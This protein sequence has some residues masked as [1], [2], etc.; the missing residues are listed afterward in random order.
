MIF[1]CKIEVFDKWCGGA[2]Y[3]ADIFSVRNKT[4]KAKG[5]VAWRIILIICG[6]MGFID[7]DKSKILKWRKKG[8]ARANDNE[9]F[10]TLD[11]FLLDLMTSGLSLFGMDSDNGVWKVKLKLLY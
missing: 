6:I 11:D 10:R 7:N 4:G 8:G 2:V 5:R 3:T 1:L 9:R